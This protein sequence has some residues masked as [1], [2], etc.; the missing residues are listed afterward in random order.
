MVLGFHT[1]VPQLIFKD[2]NRNVWRKHCP[3]SSGVGRTHLIVHYF[4][5]F[6][7][8]KVCPLCYKIPS[9]VLVS[10]WYKLL[11]GHILQLP[12]HVY[13]EQVQCHSHGTERDFRSSVT[14]DNPAML[15]TTEEELGMPWMMVLVGVP[16]MALKM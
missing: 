6:S 9:L 5:S 1:K 3:V 10:P 11:I 4:S 16:L 15:H 14:K 12:S 2:P 7:W 13:I 8:N